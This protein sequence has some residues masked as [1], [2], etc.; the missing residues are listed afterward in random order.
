MPQSSVVLC[1]KVALAARHDLAPRP[2]FLA[3]ALVLATIG[4]TPAKSAEF[5]V[6]CLGPDAHYVCAFDDVE[7]TSQD[8]RLKLLCITELAGKGGHAS[9]SVDR[10]KTSPC[11]GE[12]KVLATPEGLG[13]G[14]GSTAGA[15]TAPGPEAA[16]PAAGPGETQVQQSVNQVPSAAVKAAEPADTQTIADPET[17]KAATNADKPLDAAAKKVGEGATEVAK[18]AGSALE[19]AGNAVGHAAKKTWDCISTFFGSC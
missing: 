4:A 13:S 16:L 11:Q 5:C 19:K 3:Q 7:P 15:G 17:A 9:C 14:A 12:R 18:S 6:S 2:L 10:T 1:R 8:P